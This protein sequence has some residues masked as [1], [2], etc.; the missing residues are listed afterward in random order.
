M[1]S[2]VFVCCVHVQLLSCFSVHQAVVNSLAPNEAA[3]AFRWN[4]M[5]EMTGIQGDQHLHYS[6]ARPAIGAQ[7]CA[8]GMGAQ[9]EDGRVRVCARGKHDPPLHL[10]TF[11]R[12]SRRAG[13]R[14]KAWPQQG[15]AGMREANPSSHPSL[16]IGAPTNT[17]SSSSSPGAAACRGRRYVAGECMPGA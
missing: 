8:A 15:G 11:S 1:G 16:L 7:S 17:C 14:G 5:P 10:P 9:R 13:A 12:G 2:L 6:A 4:Q 3:A